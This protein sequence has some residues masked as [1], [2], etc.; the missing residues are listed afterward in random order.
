MAP[1]RTTV[2]F[3]CSS[4]TVNALKGHHPKKIAL[5]QPAL[6]DGTVLKHCKGPVWILLPQRLDF[7]KTTFKPVD[8]D[9]HHICSLFVNCLIWLMST[10]TCFLF[11]V[12]F[13]EYLGHYL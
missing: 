6:G 7:C 1:L 5:K 12:F 11:L 2:L 8:L 13:V 9:E 10:V 4:N 3:Y